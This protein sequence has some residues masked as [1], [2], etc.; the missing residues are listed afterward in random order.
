MEWRGRS[1]AAG[2]LSEQSRVGQNWRLWD[3]WVGCEPQLYHIL[4]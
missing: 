2:E 1:K 3:Q 4:P